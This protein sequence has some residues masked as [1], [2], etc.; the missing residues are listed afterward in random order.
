[1]LWAWLRAGQQ[2]ERAPRQNSIPSCFVSG[3]SNFLQRSKEGVILVLW[4]AF[5]R[6]LWL[7]TEEASYPAQP[8]SRHR[9]RHLIWHSCGDVLN[10][11]VKT[12]LFGED[13]QN[14]ASFKMLQLTF[15]EI[16]LIKK[17]I[18]LKDPAHIGSFLEPSKF[19]N[20]FIIVALG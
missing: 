14:A 10:G 1:M 3:Y 15:W 5:W 2:K 17:E 19:I 8:P 16:F 9:A 13:L 4:I 11:E 12:L 6:S 7:F 20:S 18:C